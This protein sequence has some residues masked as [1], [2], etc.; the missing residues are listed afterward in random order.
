MLAARPLQPAP[1]DPAPP[2]HEHAVAE[3][4]LA[5]TNEMA[6]RYGLARLSL[7]DVASHAGVS[8]QTLYR[9]FSSKDELLRAVVLREVATVA[10]HAQTAAR[11][12]TTLA[13]ALQ[14]L[15]A[16]LLEGANRHPLLQRLLA[17]EADALLP[18]LTQDAGTAQGHLTEMIREV[19]AQRSVA[20]EARQG[21]AAELAMRVLLSRAISPGQ[22]S[23]ATAAEVLAAAV[24]GVLVG[25]TPNSRRDTGR[26]AA[27]N[28]Q[29]VSPTSCLFRE[30]GSQPPRAPMR[31]HPRGR[32]Q[33][34]PEVPQPCCAP[35]PGAKFGPEVLGAGK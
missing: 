9:Y 31:A 14:A 10:A 21:Q 6:A 8:R 16:A 18:L 4:L 26:H 24:L 35:E 19:L 15:F 11:G 3:R 33:S 27:T 17:T 34:R 7:G 13:L 2:T 22:E 25:E 32:P 28:P 30:G 23:T 12:E 5:A 1:T 20:T 29:S